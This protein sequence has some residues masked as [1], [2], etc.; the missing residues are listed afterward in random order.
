LAGGA[1]AGR[2]NLPMLLSG[3]GDVSLHTGQE[4][5]RLSPRRVIMLGGTAALNAAVETRLKRLVASP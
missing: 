3:K 1:V 5:L 2:Q 4:V